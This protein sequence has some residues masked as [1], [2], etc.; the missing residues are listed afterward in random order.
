MTHS[1]LSQICG[2][3]SMYVCVS[4]SKFRPCC[5]SGCVLTGGLSPGGC[6]F[7][8]LLSSQNWKQRLGNRPNAPPPQSPPALLMSKAACDAE[9]GIHIR[10]CLSHT[11]ALMRIMLW[12]EEIFFLN[13]KWPRRSRLWC[14]FF[15]RSAG[16]YREEKVGRNKE[17]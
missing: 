6:V 10:G 17:F 3:K 5:L 15:H 1:F 16:T 11:R 8:L 12:F 14:F 7:F 4:V 9:W 13:F 2:Q